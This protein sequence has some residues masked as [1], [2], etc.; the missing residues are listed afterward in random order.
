MKDGPAF[1]PVG[2]E[3]GRSIQLPALYPGLAAAGFSKTWFEFEDGFQFAE[4]LTPARIL[5]PR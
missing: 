5:G 3:T 4:E 2:V 1:L